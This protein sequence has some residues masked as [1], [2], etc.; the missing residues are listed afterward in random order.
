MKNDNKRYFQVK[1]INALIFA[2][3]FSFLLSVSFAVDKASSPPVQAHQTKEGYDIVIL[4]DSSG[5]MKRTD[6]NDYRKSAAKLLVSLL[7]QNDRISIISFGDS[8]NVLIPLTQN[9]SGNRE[10]LF[11][12]INRVTS[13]EFSTNITEAVKRGFEALKESERKNRIIVL[14]SDGKLA[15]GDEEK[16]RIAHEEL[17]RLLPELANSGIKIYSV[18]FTEFSDL[19]LLEDIAKYTGGIFRLAKTDRDIHLIFSSIYEKMKSPDMIPLEGDVFYID[20]DIKEAVLVISKK[21]GTSTELID[22]SNRK[23]SSTRHGKN[24]LWHGAEVFDVIAI[25]N[26]TPGIWKAKLS[27]AES[28]KIYVL[29]DLSLKTSF[30]RDFV[31]AGDELNIDTWLEDKG[32]VLTEQDVLKHIAFFSEISGAGIEEPI[33]IELLAAESVDDGRRYGRFFVKNTGQYMLKIIAD[34]KTF[35]RERILQFKAIEPPPKPVEEDRPLDVKTDTWS[36][37]KPVLINFGLINLGLLIVAVL[38][39]AM[40]KLTAG[41]NKKPKGRKNK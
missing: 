40:K 31:Y 13:R 25:R 41:K 23:H 12:A 36:L 2:S 33:K 15:L 32:V 39:F 5:S 7:G 27:V 1:K 22:P 9:T 16:D 21:P 38:I 14:M 35:K 8:A 10:R 3:I 26:P 11:G 34:G 30:E 18:A 20:K 24:I 29:T 37:W 17:S 4:M 6:P 19:K 28:H